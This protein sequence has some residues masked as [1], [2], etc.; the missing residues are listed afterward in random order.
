[1]AGG[2]TLT[3]PAADLGIATAIVSSFRNIPAAPKTAVFG[4]VGLAGELRG[5]SQ[6]DMR[7]NEAKRLGFKRCVLPSHNVKS[8]TRRQLAGSGVEIVG[9]STLREAL[10]AVFAVV[11]G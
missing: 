1:V 3:E 11:D 10:E 4:E 5:V 8:M 6:A 7:V 9:A 2:V